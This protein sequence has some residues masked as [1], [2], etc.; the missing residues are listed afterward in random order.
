MAPGQ[1]LGLEVRFA[2][3]GSEPLATTLVWRDASG[4]PVLQLPARGDV[5]SPELGA[6][7]ALDFG[8]VEVGR[9]GE[10]EVVLR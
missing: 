6:T 9:R 4:R 7:A 2:P 8:V 10:R 3:R 1:A 5:Q